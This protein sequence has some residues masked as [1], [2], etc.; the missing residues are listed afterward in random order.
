MNLLKGKNILLGV[1]GSIALYRSLDLIRILQKK[2]VN[3]KVIMTKGAQ[4]FI[5]PL[6]FSSLSRNEV[7]TDFF[8]IYPKYPIIHLDLA[9]WCDTL[10]IV[11]ATA[12]IL[13]KLA[14]GVADDLLTCTVL[15]CSK[16]ILIAPA[17]N[18]HM[19]AH[20][21]IQNNINQLKTYGYQFLAPIEGKTACGEEGQGRLLSPENIAQAVEAVFSKKDLKDTKVLVTV[22]PTHEPIDPVRFIS[23][24]SSGQ[25]GF[26]VAKIAF[27]RGAEVILVSGPTCLKPPYGVN[28]LGIKTAEEMKN[29]VLAHFSSIDVVVMA[30]AISDFKPSYSAYKIKKQKTINLT[31]K[32][33][34]DILTLLGQQKTHQILVGFAAETNELITQAIKKLKAKNLDIIVANDVSKVGAGFEVATNQ[35]SVIYKNGSQEEWPLMPK[36]EV[37]FR[38]WDRIRALL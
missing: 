29:A 20:K 28:F 5:N 14:Q 1:T 9:K 11:P 24:R 21:A 33:T 22:G 26:A 6:T 31:L 19:Y 10:L 13:A 16:P 37:A 7:Y 3:I 27:Q 25:M 38:L 23:N 2:E 30:A 4:A 15:A 8:K 36:E 32:N 18:P 12:N 17:M 35:V 34:P